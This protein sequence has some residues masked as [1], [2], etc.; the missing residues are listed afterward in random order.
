MQY[1]RI[2]IPTLLYVIGMPKKY[3]NENLLR[4]DGFFG[5]YGTIKRIM[6]KSDTKDYYEQQG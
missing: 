5:Q 2:V 1:F 3:S 4:S 6:I